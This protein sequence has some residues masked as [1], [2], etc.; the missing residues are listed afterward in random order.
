MRINIHV[1][2]RSSI[3]KITEQP[4]GSFKVKLTA[5]PVEGAANEKLIELV[6]KK[7]DVA[8]KHVKIIKGVKGKNKIIDI[9]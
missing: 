4:D 8:K 6:A 3:N 9:I 2:P 5:P 1:I 7:F